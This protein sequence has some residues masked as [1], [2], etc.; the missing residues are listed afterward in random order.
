VTIGGVIDY[1]L[2]AV[3]HPAYTEF[4]AWI[5][6]YPLYAVPGFQ[7]LI[8]LA[9]V[10]D[11]TMALYLVNLRLP[12]DRRHEGRGSAILRKLIEIADLHGVPII[13]EASN[14]AESAAW[15]PA[16]YARHGFEYTGDA[17]DYGPWMLRPSS[18]LALT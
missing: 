9:R 15:L 1:L 10:D 17:G 18:A 7:V 11:L 16:W 4:K 2:G 8:S 5:A 14:L 12:P 6:D 3:P 13:L